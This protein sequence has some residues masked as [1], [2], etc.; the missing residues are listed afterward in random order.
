M[1]TCGLQASFNLSRAMESF[2]ILNKGSGLSV[3]FVH[4]WGFMNVLRS[5]DL[6]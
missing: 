5:A 4:F 1:S 2:S 6:G 3:N